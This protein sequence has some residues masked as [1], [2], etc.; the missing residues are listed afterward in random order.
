PAIVVGDSTTGETQ[1]YDGPYYALGWLLRQPK[2][3]V[4]PVIGDASAFRFNIV[5]RDFVVGAIAHLS[6]DGRSKDRV[7]Q[8]ADPN[9]LTVTDLYAEMAEATGKTMI[10][11]PMTRGLAKF[12]IDRLP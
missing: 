2:F 11:V 7:Y 6:G 4:M 1:K 3:A 12:S 8:L 9:P 5:P 10:R